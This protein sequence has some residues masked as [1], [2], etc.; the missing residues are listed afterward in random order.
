VH[1]AFLSIFPNTPGFSVVTTKQ[2]HPSYAFA[3]S[4]EALTKLMLASKQVGLLLDQALSGVAR[5]GLILEGFGVDHLHAKLV[6]RRWRNGS[7][8]GPTWT[9]FS[10]ATKD[11]CRRMTIVGRT[12]GNSRIWPPS[13]DAHG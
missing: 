6:P 8:F 1:L 7:P 10:L 2:H 11:T 5:T 3:G 13:S 12:T 9:G 4:D